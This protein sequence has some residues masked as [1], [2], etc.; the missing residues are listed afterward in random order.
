MYI[1]HNYFLPSP[2]DDWCRQ[3][4]QHAKKIRR[5][6]K[7]FFS[8][9]ISFFSSIFSLSIWSW[10]S[11]HGTADGSLFISASTFLW[12]NF[13][14]HF[15][16][17]QMHFLRFISVF[18]WSSAILK[19]KD[20]SILQKLKFCWNN[21]VLYLQETPTTIYLLFLLELYRD[22]RTLQYRSQACS[23]YHRIEHQ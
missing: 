10:Q 19:K 15:L 3:E 6:S 7:I 5:F 21:L 16:V 18:F 11:L 4:Q 17:L 20:Q 12:L 1:V 2:S 14:T 22:S 8:R 23:S 13:R 9:S